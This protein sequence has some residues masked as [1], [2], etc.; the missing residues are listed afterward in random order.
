MQRVK[1][2]PM[3][4]NKIYLAFLTAALLLQS[5]VSFSQYK[6]YDPDNGIKMEGDYILTKNGVMHKYPAGISRTAQR[7]G[8]LKIS[9]T[10]EYKYSEIIS[11]QMANTNYRV[12]NSNVYR[13]IVSGKINV[14]NT[15]TPTPTS[16][17][18]YLQKG[19]SDK[20]VFLYKE[21][22]KG[23]IYQLLMDNEKAKKILDAKLDKNNKLDVETL[24]EA[25]NAYNNS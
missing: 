2:T 3:R 21:K 7:F 15:T 5:T 14:Y 10:E 20:L 17:N 8:K 22:G 25:V 18:V 1:L 16:N 11:F 12:I 19:D 4:N 6:F 23:D 13:R 24:V 9:D